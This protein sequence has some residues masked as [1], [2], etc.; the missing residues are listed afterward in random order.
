M[1]INELAITNAKF[2]CKEIHKFRREMTSRK[3]KSNIEYLL[4]NT[5]IRKH[6]WNIR[7]ERG[8]EIGR[9]YYLLP[10]G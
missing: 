1:K 5:E 8:A 7:E 9:D 6:V 3:D 2:K 10:S 4:N